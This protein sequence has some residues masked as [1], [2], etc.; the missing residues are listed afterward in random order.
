MTGT[1]FLAY[2]K[3]QFKRTDKDTEIYDAATDTVIDMRLRM[4]SEKYKV[5]SASTSLSTVG[6]YAMA[7]PDDFGHIIG[8]IS[9]KDDTDEQTYPPL[10][11]ISVE[12]FDRL[13]PDRMLDIAE[14]NTGVP[15]HFCVYG[16]VIYVGPC[17]DKTTYKFYINYTE[18]DM[19]DI[20][21]S[22]TTVPFTDQYREAVKAGTLMRIYR[23][24][25]VYAE[26]DVWERIY[27]QGIAKIAASDSVNADEHGGS[28]CYSG[29]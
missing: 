8:Q 13:Y 15:K 25:E 11:K 12:D 24:L 6:D 1:E 20:D 7:V 5:R 4:Y 26:A 16:E 28:I 22:T 17:I 3:R 19:E 29:I 27:E 21:G 2:I 9:F 10:K 14:R 23:D 18:E